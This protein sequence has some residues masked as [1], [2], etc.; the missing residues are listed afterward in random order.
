[1]VVGHSPSDAVP[2]RPAPIFVGGVGRS[3]T[4]PMGRTIDA[5]PRYCWIKT[6]VRF[7][8]SKGGL[9]DVCRGETTMEKFLERMRGVWWKRGHRMKQGMQRI[10]ASEE[11]YEAAL[12][13]FETAFE[14]DRFG[15]SRELLSSLLD[16]YAVAAGKPAWV[17]I[18]GEVIEEA[19]YLLQLYPGA[20][21]I[22]M[23]RDGRAV[24]AG[25]LRKVDLTDDRRQAIQ[26]W[27]EMVRAADAEMQRVPE[28]RVLTVFL[29]DFTALNREAT[30]ARLVAFLETEEEDPMRE[31]FEHEI[32]AARAHVGKWRERIAPADA[33]MLDRRYRKIVRGLRG[34]GIEWVPEPEA[35]RLAALR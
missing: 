14:T 29:D 30:F 31:Y 8:A 32:S 9:P 13:R 4:H 26:K 6:E 35:R 28:D 23:V 33:R 24:A 20:K 1:M 16:P 19:S 3:G 21:F 12:E 25:M 17:E 10:A 5:D 11:V 27:E 15:A 22:N 34:D 7:H 2:G 18:T